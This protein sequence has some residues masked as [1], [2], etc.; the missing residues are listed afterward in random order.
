M[1]WQDP[2]MLVEISFLNSN[3]RL[4]NSRN[5][6]CRVDNVEYLAIRMETTTILEETPF[7][8][9]SVTVCKNRRTM[10]NGRAPCAKPHVP[11]VRLMVSEIVQ[12]LISA[13][14]FSNY[15]NRI[16][17]GQRETSNSQR[18]VYGN[19]CRT[20]RRFSQRIASERTEFSSTIPKSN[21]RF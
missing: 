9:L 2:Q 10:H 7:V 16:R 17:G 21:P 4:K 6:N 18:V 3:G 19:L 15:P 13:N 12:P 1:A 11:N 8:R 5:E 14:T 20:H